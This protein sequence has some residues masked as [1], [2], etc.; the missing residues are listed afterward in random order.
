VDRLLDE[1]RSAGPS[2]DTDARYREVQQRYVSEPSYVFL[3]FL[4]HTYAYRDLGWN[5]TAPILEP[6][7]HGV[8]WGPW[9][10]VAGWTR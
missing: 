9:W 4:D 8:S 2:P 6:H 1:A 3:A 10:H 7:S 5:Q